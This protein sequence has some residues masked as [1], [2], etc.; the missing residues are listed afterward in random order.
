MVPTRIRMTYS[1]GGDK[2]FHMKR[3]GFWKAALQCVAAAAE[4]M[5]RLERSDLASLSNG[6]S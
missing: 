4:E 1:Y 2:G 3:W 5:D 6:G